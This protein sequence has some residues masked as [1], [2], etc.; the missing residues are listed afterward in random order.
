MSF[1]RILDL[2]AI[3]RATS[4]ECVPCAAEVPELIGDDYP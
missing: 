4:G 2:S 1:A 3:T